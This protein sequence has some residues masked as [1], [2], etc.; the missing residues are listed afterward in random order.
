V[1]ARSH[2]KQHFQECV[3]HLLW[4]HHAAASRDAARQLAKTVTPSVAYNLIVLASVGYLLHG[5]RFN[6]AALIDHAS[7]A[8]SS[9][10][11]GKLPANQVLLGNQCP[12]PCEREY[13]LQVK[14]S[15][16][17]L[18]VSEGKRLPSDTHAT[19]FKAWMQTAPK[20]EAGSCRCASGRRR[21]KATA[22]D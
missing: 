21:S 10:F 20:A 19:Q 1:C 7:S 12:L 14:L 6:L 17:V 13:A 18:Y 11:A 16:L 22:E 8:P 2:T 9:T 4:L 15:E 5:P 3:A